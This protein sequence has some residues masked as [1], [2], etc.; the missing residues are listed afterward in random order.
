[1]VNSS[2]TPIA[3]YAMCTLKLP[4]GVIDN[5]DR[6]RKQCLWRG[7]N[8]TARGGHLAAWPMVSKPKVKGGL[9]ILNLRLQNDALLLKQLNKFYNRKDVPW[10][11]LIWYRYY[12]QGKVPHGQKEVGSFW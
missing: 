2:I 10:V 12:D 3:T 5:M 1:M 8:R 9:G 6:I 11:H 7:N 4:A